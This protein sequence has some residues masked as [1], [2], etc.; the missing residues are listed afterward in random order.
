MSAQAAQWKVAHEMAQWRIEQLKNSRQL[1]QSQLADARLALGCVEDHTRRLRDRIGQLRAAGARLDLTA[2]DG[3]R[4]RRVAQE[5]LQRVEG[6]LAEAH[7]RL[8]DARQQAIRRP[9]DYSI[10]PYDGPNQT[11]RRPIYLECRADAVVLQP[12]GIAFHESDFA[13]SL[14]P[15]NP[16]AAALRAVR[17]YLADRGAFD[18]RADGEPYP[19]LLVRPQGIMTYYAARAA[20]QWWAADFGYELIEDDWKLHFPAP[21]LQLAKVVDRAI[22]QPRAELAA[23]AVDHAR[24]QAAFAS[25]GGGDEDGFTSGDSGS[26]HGGAG[27]GRGGGG[28]G[29]YGTGAASGPGGYAVGAATGPGGGSPGGNGFGSGSGGGAPGTGGFGGS[30]GSGSGTMSGDSGGSIFGSGSGGGSP[31]NGGL[32]GF[33]GAGGSGSGTMSGGSGG[34]IFGSGSGGGAPGNGGLGGLGGTGGSGSGTMSGGSGG[35]IFGSGSGG[36]SPGSGGLGGFGGTGGSG[37]GTMSSWASGPGLGSGSGDGASGG[38]PFGGLGGTGASGTAGGPGGNGLGMGLSGGT[39]AGGGTA[40][41]GLAGDPSAQN[42]GGASVKRPDDFVFGQPQTATDPAS[43]RPP[44][45]GTQPAAPLRPGEWRPTPDPPP[46]DKAD[47]KDK[48]K[49]LKSLAKTR[50]EDWALR[51]AGRKS[52]PFT[53]NIRVDCYADRLIL[54]PDAGMGSPK[55]IP[56]GPRTAGSVDKLVAALWERMD[57]WGIAGENMYW[58]PVLNVYV[59]PGADRRFDD[60]KVLLE[61]SGFNLQ[62]K[63]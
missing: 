23:A 56:L 19:L 51:D 24:R 28:R 3:G 2:A 30:G 53:R 46:E 26:T 22:V 63:P 34:S 18:P 43:Q 11:H 10:I 20:M 45:A 5:E 35:S 25:Y 54:A 44:P 12:E 62:R 6:E 59:A 60:L 1:T 29:G 50:G 47:D 21:D 8:T 14:G 36:G 13:G 41:S 16:L 7:R 27:G 32:G 40:F 9:H 55:Q 37:S 48:Q 42:Q 61:G 33:G 4:Q 39:A 49:D 15:D 38:S 52:T 57:S 17:E 31:G 58:R